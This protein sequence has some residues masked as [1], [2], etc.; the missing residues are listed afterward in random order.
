[1]SLINSTLPT[2][3]LRM[4]DLMGNV[5]TQRLHS[6]IF[7]AYEVKSL[8][9]EALNE[10]QQRVLFAHGGVIPAQHP[11]GPPLVLESWA[12]LAACHRPTN[13]YQLLPRRAR[14]YAAYQV[15]RS[16]CACPGSPFTMDQRVDPIDLKLIF[17]PPDFEFR[18]AFNARNPEKVGTSVQ[19]DGLLR[20]DTDTG[21]V[22]CFSHVTPAQIN[23]FVGTVAFLRAWAADTVESER[24][25]DLKGKWGTMLSRRTHCFIAVQQP[26]VSKDAL[27]FAKAKNVH[28][29]AKRHAGA[30]SFCA[31]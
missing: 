11:V 5:Y 31:T 12:D 24:H 2:L 13:L 19:F 20:T 30:F 16:I 28:V 21:L 3:N 9:L 8:V 15:A 27:A 7:D 18:A 29:F 23:T 22:M 14:S 17:R 1:M 10:N 6:R 25:R 26:V 4:R